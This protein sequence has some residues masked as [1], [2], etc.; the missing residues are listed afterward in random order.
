[1]D[2]IVYATGFHANKFLW[3]MRIVG[4]DGRD[5]RELWGEDPRA[6]Y[7]MTVPGFPNFFCIYGPN[8]NL[9]VNGSAIFFTE[10]SVRYILGCLKLLLGGNHAT[11]ECR[12][13]VHDEFNRIIDEGNLNMA[14]GAHPIMS[15]YKNRSGRVTQ[16]WPFRTQR[17]W[18]E[19]RA[20]DPSHFDLR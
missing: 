14:W 11:I 10:C 4:R 15:W 16:N 6:F 17:Y 2:V 1:M 20:P 3:P 7:G 9:V 18:A 12:Q 5:L 8:T 13:D 19:T